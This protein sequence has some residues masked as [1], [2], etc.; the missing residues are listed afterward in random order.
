MSASDDD[1]EVVIRALYD[2]F[3]RRDIAA[4]ARLVDPDV[5]FW[6]QGT[7]ERTGRSAPY[8]GVDGL[9]AYFA[10]VAEHWDELRVEPD[11]L[12]I[13]GNG[14]VAFGTA[15]GRSG[16][17]QVSQPVIWVWKLRDGRILSGR[18]VATAAQAMAVVADAE[19]P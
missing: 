17:Q 4:A 5:H 9:R 15:Y 19:A 11:E 7:A 13:A 3:A 16:E 12:R 8:R 1:P 6:P 14:V 18:V 10:D 2:A